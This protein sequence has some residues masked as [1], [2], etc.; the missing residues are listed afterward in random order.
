MLHEI[1]VGARIY[2]YPICTHYLKLIAIGIIRI[3]NLLS[4]LVLYPL[5]VNE[6]QPPSLNLT[7]DKGTSK[8]S[9][10]LLGLCVA[11]RLA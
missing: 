1:Y 10:D 8:S 4:G 2:S 7:V 3:V 9:Q 11:F 6:V 5:C